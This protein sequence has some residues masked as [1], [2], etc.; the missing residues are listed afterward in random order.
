MT[1]RVGNGSGNLLVA[2]VVDKSVWAAGPSEQLSLLPFFQQHLV[3]RL[4]KVTH[5]IRGGIPTQVL[6]LHPL[7]RHS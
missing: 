2:I 7:I 6:A 3:L 1:A 5:I 4:E